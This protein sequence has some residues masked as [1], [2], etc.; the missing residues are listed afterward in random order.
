MR[1]GYFHPLDSCRSLCGGVVKL[2][3]GVE[4]RM[5]KAVIFWGIFYIKI[6][7]IVAIFDLVHDVEAFKVT[8]PILNSNSM[9]KSFLKYE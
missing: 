3:Q 9:W 7:C 4:H 1:F 6:V 8:W 2:W 5:V